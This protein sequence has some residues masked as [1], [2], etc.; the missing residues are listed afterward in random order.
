M[1]ARAVERVEEMAKGKAKG[2][3]MMR[4]F[5]SADCCF[6]VDNEGLGWLVSWFV[7]RL[8]GWLVGRS[9]D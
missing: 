4:D 6:L 7:S 9:V 5:S 2:K 1:N 8:V 3:A